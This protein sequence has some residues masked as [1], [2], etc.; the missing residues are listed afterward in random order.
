M[1]RRHTTIASSTGMSD[2]QSSPLFDAATNVYLT[3]EPTS[4]D[5]LTVGATPIPSQTLSTL[6]GGMTVKF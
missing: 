5:A 6:T 3:Y 1:K 2:D 4:V